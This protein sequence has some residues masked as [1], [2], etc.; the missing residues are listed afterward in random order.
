[1]NIKLL[2]T[3]ITLLIIGLLMYFN[4][5]KRKPASEETN[6]KGQ[7]PPQFTQFWIWAI[8]GIVVG[9]VLILK[10]L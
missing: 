10:S 7:L 1:M 2:L 5:R 8:V 4:V 9:V 6:W 3:G